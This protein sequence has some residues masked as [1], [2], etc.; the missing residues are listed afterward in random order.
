MA[1]IAFLDD[2]FAFTGSSFRASPL[3]GVQSATVQLAEALAKRGHKVTV[4]G[5]VEAPEEHYGVR[6]L[7]LAGP[8][9]TSFDFIIANRAPHL[10][11]RAEGKKRALWLHNP[12]N[13][14]R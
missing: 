6:Y 1:S 2:S 7:P 11:R 13:Y 4:R 9:E 12:A 3:G 10:L 14:L 8:G 5:M